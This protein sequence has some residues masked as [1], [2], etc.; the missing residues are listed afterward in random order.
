MDKL[1]VPWGC[2]MEMR[3]LGFNEPCIA[4]WHFYTKTIN[5][6]SE[7]TKN[8]NDLTVPLPLYQQAFDWFES[9]GYSTIDIWRDMNT[10]GYNINIYR[11][12]ITHYDSD[13]VETLD[14]ARA[15]AL[16]VLI[17]F[18]KQLRS[19]PTKNILAES[20]KIRQIEIVSDSD[21]YRNIVGKGYIE[22]RNMTFVVGE[23]DVTAIEVVHLLESD[24]M[25]IYIK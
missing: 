8:G 20:K 9:L 6:L 16:R 12:Q 14:K 2:A 21:Q 24:S 5:H 4:S 25:V 17:N 19:S 18:E 10:G 23:K 7:P 13:N 11:N 22:Q 1:F 3:D 15:S